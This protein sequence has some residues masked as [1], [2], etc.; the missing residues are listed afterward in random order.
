MIGEMP[1]TRTKMPILKIKGGMSVKVLPLVKEPIGFHSHWLGTRSFMCPGV[2][3][4]ACFAAVGTRWVGF[5]P[6]RW[7]NELGG[8]SHVSVLELT[9]GSYER[10]E[11]LRKM[12]GH[13][14]LLSMLCDVSRARNRS[15]LVLEPMD[16]DQEC[17]RAT[18]P[19]PEWLLLDA[20]ATLYGLP[21]CADGSSRS[22]WEKLAV[23]RAIQLIRVALPKALG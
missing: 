5:L 13:G 21:A 19:F 22:D 17:E 20:I 4:P 16:A 7:F 9:A 10:L 3:C 12:M 1:R 6:V 8:D 15:V 11:G 14:S 2:N 23:P 18:K